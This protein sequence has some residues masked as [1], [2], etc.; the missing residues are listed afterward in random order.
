MIY[1]VESGEEK[2][3]VPTHATSNP[4]TFNASENINKSHEKS[5]T[6]MAPLCH[7]SPDVD[8]LCLLCCNVK[9]FSSQEP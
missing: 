9:D 1:Y 2:V 8:A 5:S 4:S 6:H 7:A 3:L